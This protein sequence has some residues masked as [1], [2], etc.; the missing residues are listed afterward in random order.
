MADPVY[1]RVCDVPI[2]SAGL[3]S[4]G[5][6][7]VT[8]QEAFAVQGLSQAD[9]TALLSAS[10]LLLVTAFIVRAIRKTIEPKM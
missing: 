9:F 3:C 6:R 5:Y 8:T 10:I 1:I 4:A 2:N 7:V